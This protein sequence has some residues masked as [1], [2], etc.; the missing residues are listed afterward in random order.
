LKNDADYSRYRLYRFFIGD[1]TLFG[2][3]H[4]KEIIIPIV[5]I[6]T[7]RTADTSGNTDTAVSIRY[8]SMGFVDFDASVLHGIGPVS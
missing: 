6:N 2:H 5:N 1:K 3:L 7:Q 4:Q 8:Q